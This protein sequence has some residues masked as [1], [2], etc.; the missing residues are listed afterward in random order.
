MAEFQD[1]FKPSYF[2]TMQ[3]IDTK[4]AAVC[5]SPLCGTRREIIRTLL[6]FEI[7]SYPLTA[8]EVHEFLQKPAASPEKTRNRLAQ[9]VEQGLVFEFDGA[10]F[11]TKNRP[12]W[13]QI[14]LENNARAVR[15]L[16]ISRRVGRFIG[17]FPFV[18]GVFVSGSLSKGSM[19]KDGDIDFFVVTEPGRL[20][21][22]RT[23]LILF[24][25]IFLLNSHKYFCINYLVDSEHLEI[26]EK[27]QFTAIETVTLV[28]VYGADF[29]QK[30]MAANGWARPFYPHFPLR[31]TSNLPPA[32]AGFFK[33]GLEKI[34][35]GPFGD[36]LDERGF[37][38]TTNF[39]KKKFAHFDEATFQLALKSNRGVSKH[40]PLGFQTKVLRRLGELTAAFEIENEVQIVD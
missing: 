35:A 40:H 26:A 6:Y 38:L 1:G 28:P 27:N 13:L 36:R 29:Y 15:F 21:L 39:W 17:S 7:F 14:R 3:E 30:F 18:R 23:M 19:A 20:W 4:S 24:K 22:A 33:K 16:K 31:D 9:L 37:R 11:S 5:S 34:L 32:G 2:S 12:D 10:F 8:D 25:K